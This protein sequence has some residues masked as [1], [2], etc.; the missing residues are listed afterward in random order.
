VA[1]RAIDMQTL[2]G[3]GEAAANGFDPKNFGD[4][5][6][7]S[8]RNDQSPE[9]GLQENVME[10]ASAKG[11]ERTRPMCSIGGIL[12]TPDIEGP[13]PPCCRVYEKENFEGLHYD[14]CHYGPTH[15]MTDRYYQA[16]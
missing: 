16:D 12:G 5:D 1:I 3:I 11:D 13:S 14:F 15:D 9:Q 7:L 6:A 4:F 10:Y 8:G 2:R